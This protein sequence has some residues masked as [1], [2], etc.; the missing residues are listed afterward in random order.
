MNKSI[1]DKI[2]SGHI[3]MS[4]GKVLSPEVVSNIANSIFINRKTEVFSAPVS[5]L[6]GNVTL[7]TGEIIPRGILSA[8]AT[9][10]NKVAQNQDPKE[11]YFKAQEKKKES[12]AISGSKSCL[13]T[14][15][16]LAYGPPSTEILQVGNL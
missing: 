11:N 10:A 16:E 13:Y 6:A 2:V 9:N 1:P 14:D 8:V 3:V 4:D 12:F 15:M 5:I 7:T